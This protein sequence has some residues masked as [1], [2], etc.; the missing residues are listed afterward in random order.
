M[1]ATGAALGLTVDLYTAAGVKL[2]SF[3]DSLPPYGYKQV[4]KVFERVTAQPVTDGYAIVRTTTAG[5]AFVAYAS[6]VDNVT[7]DPVLVVPQRITGSAPPTPTPTPVSVPMSLLATTTMAFD[8]LR[9]AGTGGRP[10][11]EQTI[12]DLQTKGLDGFINSQVQRWPTILTKITNG[13]QASYGSG[14][15]LSDGTVLK[16]SATGTTTD[17]VITSTKVQGTVN[18]SLGN[19][20]VNDAG[21]LIPVKTV[22]VNLTTDS[23]HHASGTIAVSGSSQTAQGPATI[24]GSV[25]VNTA[26]CARYPVGGSVS[27]THDGTTKTIV[28]NNRCDGSFGYQGA[29]EYAKFDTNFMKCDGSGYGYH[30]TVALARDG[31][32]LVVDPTC[33]GASNLGSRDHRVTGNISATAVTLHFRSWYGDHY[34]QGTFTGTSTNGV[35]YTGVATY[36]VTAYNVS[37]DPTSGVRCQSQVFTSQPNDFSLWVLPSS[38]CSP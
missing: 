32:V 38:Y 20:T 23:Q 29:L 26:Q 24:S 17:A 16:G 4:D 31:N 27:V 30:F 18:V 36:T 25:Q 37:H 14:T 3:S 33:G 2:G 13:V 7:G 34:Y 21:V 5:G 10:T 11:V 28:F 12:L 15:T 9:L 35:V 19:L 1:N 22:T 8:R 6:V